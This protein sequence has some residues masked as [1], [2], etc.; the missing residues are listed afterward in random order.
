M[1]LPRENVI[2][3]SVFLMVKQALY[4]AGL[5]EHVELVA[6]WPDDPVRD[7][8]LTRNVVAPV[9][10]FGPEPEPAEM[11][12]GLLRA[13]YLFCV[14]VFGLNEQWLGAIS[15]A[16]RDHLLREG[17]IP[18]YDFEATGMPVM[19]Y[20]T[21]PKVTTEPVHLEEPLAWEHFMRIVKVEV[22]DYYVP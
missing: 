6:G 5:E 19:D 11:G 9:F 4:D 1:S 15:T 14:Y 12:S 8:P 17:R 13:D 7:K 21:Y 10:D 18:L 3:E 2:A 16:I 22:E 20:L